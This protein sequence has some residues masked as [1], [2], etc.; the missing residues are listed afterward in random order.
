MECA[1]ATLGWDERVED[2]GK[3]NV[4]PSHLH[5]QSCYYV[6]SHCNVRQCL[7][8]PDCIEAPTVTTVTMAR[9][10]GQAVNAR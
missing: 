5:E 6:A 10:G 3:S 2:A 9:L 8:E 1:E 4:L 7:C